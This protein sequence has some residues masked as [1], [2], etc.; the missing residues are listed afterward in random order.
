M[1]SI[2]NKSKI[3]FILNLDLNSL[4]QEI[5]ELE[6][7]KEKI[8]SLEDLVI[9]LFQT[10][11]ENY[12]T[13]K[14]KEM[15]WA[16]IMDLFYHNDNIMDRLKLIREVVEQKHICKSL[17]CSI[18]EPLSKCSQII[19]SL[20]YYTK[21]EIED[22]TSDEDTRMKRLQRFEIAKYRL[23]EVFDD[24]Q[25]MAEVYSTVRYDVDLKHQ[26]YRGDLRLAKDVSEDGDFYISNVGSLFEYQ[27]QK[28]Q[29][30]LYGEKPPSQ[31][32]K[33]ELRQKEEQFQKYAEEGKRNKERA[34]KQ[35]GKNSEKIR[36]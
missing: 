27:L 13:E 32:E 6:T 11:Q 8:Q 1:I 15:N 30:E 21:K 25:K 36:R 28:Q 14:Y 24:V 16:T 9:L 26:Y 7:A 3:Q 5:H 17:E 18:Y 23:R 19:D 4:L 10:Y 33:E 2:K 31:D 12:D 22:N 20:P 35:Y 34:D 29:Q